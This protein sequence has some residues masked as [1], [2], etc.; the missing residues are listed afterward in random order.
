MTNAIMT[1]RWLVCCMTFAAATSGAQAAQPSN[2]STD[3]PSRPVR[4]VVGLPAG[5]STDVVARVV[6]TGLAETLRQNV[7]VDNRVGR[8]GIVAGE[9][10]AKQGSADGHTLLFHASFYSEILASV[11]G[12][13][14]YDPM[15]DFTPV[16]LVTKIPNVL[17]VHPGVPAHNVAEL[18]A[19]A[20]SRP[21]PLHYASSG[22][23]SSAHLSMELFKQRAKVAAEHVPYKGVPQALIDLFSGQMSVMFGNIPGQLPHLRSGKLRALAVT[24]LDRSFQLPD[25]PTM[26]EAGIPGFEITVWYGVLAPTQT[27][28][29]LVQKLDAAIIKTLERPEVAARMM[30]HGA[31]PQPLPAQSFNSFRRAE[32]A[33]WTQLVRDAGIRTN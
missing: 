31:K 9:R 1:R 3:F 27:P 15:G 6:G 18:V 21:K 30:E 5:G 17:V 32:T 7:V 12:T 19:H 10:I 23:G 14:P 26:H 2:A 29:A 20:K 8:S 33:K 4:L 24:S 13:L 28:P 11:E 22:N 16:T 25:V